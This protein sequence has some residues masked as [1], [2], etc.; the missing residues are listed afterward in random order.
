MAR[1]KNNISLAMEEEMQDFLQ[2]YVQSNHIASV[3]K[4]V[5]DLIDTYLRQEKK[6]TIVQ[7]DPDYIPI[8]LKIPVKLKG[9]RDGLLT[10]LKIRAVGIAERL[11]SVS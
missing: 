5:R 2:K 7:H 11:T 1:K 8:V 3:S 9:D 4:L 6:I 10:W